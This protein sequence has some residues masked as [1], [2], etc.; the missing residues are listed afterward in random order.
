[1]CAS[2][3]RREFEV[4]VYRRHPYDYLLVV[5]SLWMEA[6]FK[7]RFLNLP[8]TTTRTAA[9]TIDEGERRV[10][11][12]IVDRFDYVQ[13][14]IWIGF[15]LSWAMQRHD[16]S[17]SSCWEGMRGTPSPPVFSSPKSPPPTLLPPA[18]L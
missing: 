3:H 1:M 14:L 4:L 16:P 8:S 6:Y 15:P 5:S 17:P 13:V 2:V 11:N 12:F 7:R 9:R 10:A 18:H